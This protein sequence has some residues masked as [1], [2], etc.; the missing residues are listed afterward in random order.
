M[1][2]TWICICF[3]KVI[4]S[5]LKQM[6]LFECTYVKFL[7]MY[8]SKSFHFRAFL[9]LHLEGEEPNDIYLYL[10]VFFV[11]CTSI[12]PYYNFKNQSFQVE[13]II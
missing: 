3:I 9:F 7:F 5:N 2:G 10:Y 4:F 8:S 6:T 11:I 1:D 12:M 13:C